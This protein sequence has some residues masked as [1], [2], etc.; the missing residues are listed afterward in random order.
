M[1]KDLTINETN[2]NIDKNFTDLKIK[3]INTSQVLTSKILTIV[4]EMSAVSYM[5]GY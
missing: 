4:Y 2:F 3:Q 1:Q 5:Y